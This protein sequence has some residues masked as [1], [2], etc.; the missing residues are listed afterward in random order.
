MVV[1]DDFAVFF[2]DLALA[3]FVTVSMSL[4]FDRVQTPTKASMAS[5]WP[6]RWSLYMASAANLLMAYLALEL[7]ADLVR[8]DRTAAA[9]GAR[10]RRRS[11][12]SYGRVASAVMIYGMSWL[13][14][15]AGS[16]EFREIN[17][18]L[19]RSDAA[20]GSAAP[21][22]SPSS[23]RSRPCSRARLQDRGGAAPTWAP[24]VYQGAP[25]PVTAVRRIEGGGVRALDPL[26]YS[27]F[28]RRGGRLDR[29]RRRRLAGTGW[30]SAWRR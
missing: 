10:A 6:D 8:A 25:I 17:A 1:V 4:G 20:L 5:C 23:S 26:F 22:R 21:T 7:G 16:L 14:G 30:S 2:V 9:I 29:A 3:A 28:A 15:L 12:T 19:F 18:A 11:S 24:D 27:G 13:Y